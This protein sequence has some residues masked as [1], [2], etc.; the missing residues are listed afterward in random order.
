MDELLQGDPWRGCEDVLVED[1]LEWHQDFLEWHRDFL[2]RSQ[3]EGCRE[4]VNPYFDDIADTKICYW[5]R[6]DHTGDIT[7]SCILDDGV[8]S[9]SLP[10]LQARLAET[11]FNFVQ[12][13]VG[14]V[15]VILAKDL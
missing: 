3:L 6:E 12:E 7:P 13:P 9:F 5:R 1:L 14:K 2:Q 4:N 11:R 15:H 10:T 8:E